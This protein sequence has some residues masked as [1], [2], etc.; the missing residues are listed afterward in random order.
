MARYVTIFPLSL[1]L[2]MNV[3]SSET[4]RVEAEG[5]DGPYMICMAHIL[6]GFLPLWS[7]SLTAGCLQPEASFWGQ[8]LLGQVA[9]YHSLT[10][11]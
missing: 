4:G 3:S 2:C 10:S 7:F 9:P 8:T 5:E 6:S 1:G 11:K